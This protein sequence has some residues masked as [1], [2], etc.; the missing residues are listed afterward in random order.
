M[1]TRNRR[2]EWHQV[3]G[4]WTRSLGE[5]GMRVRLFQ[6]R[7][8]GTFYRAVWVRGRGHDRA[9]LHTRD[10]GEAERLAKRFL[11]ALLTGQGQEPGN[12]RLTLK[13]LWE[14]FKIECPSF[15]DNKPRTR[16]EAEARARVLMAFFG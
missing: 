11:G 2:N 5:R 15:L 3:H 10:R 1:A 9:C 8:N 16:L 12:G 4:R 14:R 13:Q 6:K 7:S